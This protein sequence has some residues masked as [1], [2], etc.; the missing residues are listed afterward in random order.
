ML[1]RHGTRWGL[2]NSLTAGRVVTDSAPQTQRRRV[3]RP[4]AQSANL[5]K[6]VATVPMAMCGRTE[7]R[8]ALPCWARCISTVVGAAVSSEDRTHMHTPTSTYTHIQTH[9][10]THIST[11]I[12]AHTYIQH[13]HISTPIRSQLLTHKQIQRIINAPK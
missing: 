7:E 2:G 6:H 1:G 10:H 5:R 3:K 12:C 4:E 8:G 11:P 9:T 13:T